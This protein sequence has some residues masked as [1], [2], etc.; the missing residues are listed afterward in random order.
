[1][2]EAKTVKA[3]KYDDDHKPSIAII[4]SVKNKKDKEIAFIQ[5]FDVYQDSKDIKRK[6]EFGGGLDTDLKDKYEENMDNKINKGGKVKGV[7]FFKLKDT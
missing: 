1:M 5:A 7:Q 6:L 4:Y 2:L 3:S